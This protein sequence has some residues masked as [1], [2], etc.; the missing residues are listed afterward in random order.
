MPQGKPGSGLVE[1]AGLHRR[2]DDPVGYMRAYQR[3][4]KDKINEYHREYYHKRIA[5]D[6][7]KR[8]KH[9]ERGV[10]AR[11]KAKYGITKE[12]YDALLTKQSG[13]CKICESQLGCD[14]RV[15]HNHETGEIRGLL[16]PNCNSGLGLFKEDP[17]RLEN[18][19][20]YLKASTEKQRV[21]R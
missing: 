17:Q 5:S 1:A 11:R 19:I 6:P 7:E 20:A 21:N 13:R 4:N 10:W 2:R 15:D 16:C 12:Q 14:L 8:A 18:A 9:L 3:A